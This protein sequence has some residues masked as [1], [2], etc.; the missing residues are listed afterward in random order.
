MEFRQL[1]LFIAVANEKNFSKAAEDVFLSQ[2]TVSTHIRNLEKELGKTLL[3][4]STK[5][6]R[7]TEDGEI[8][9]K[10]ARRIM[11]MKE[12]ALQA[13]SGTAESI[14]HIGASTIP[15]GYLLPPVMG[16]YH[17]NHAGIYFDISQGD[18]QSILQKV[19]DGTVE[20][21]IVGQKENASKCTFLPFCSDQLMLITP[22]N[23]H[24]LELKKKNPEIAELLKEPIILRE[25]GSGTQKAADRF[26]EG[27][28]VGPEKLRVIARN[29]DLE[30][31]K[32]MVADGVGISIISEYAVQDLIQRGQILAYPLQSRFRRK[33]YL[34]YLKE[35]SLKPAAKEF[36]QYIRHYYRNSGV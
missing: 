20:F 25:N 3:E 4:R 26:L 17:E 7:L 27:I 24:Y 23:D 35:R 14:L 31:I 13:L 18:S 9:L 22:S 8:F 16:A 11:D 32:R 28:H 5:S 29:N 30:S 6:V 36:I 1:E 34:T 12:A 33:F 15:S 2:S 21:G 10:Y 19:Q